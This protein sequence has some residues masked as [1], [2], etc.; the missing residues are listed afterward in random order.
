MSPF[1]ACVLWLAETEIPVPPLFSQMAA[2]SV[3]SLPP[4]ASRDPPCLSF[5]LFCPVRCARMLLL[6]AGQS[7]GE[8]VLALFCLSNEILMGAL[9]FFSSVRVIQHFS[10][11]SLLRTFLAR[12]LAQN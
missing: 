5:G 3:D 11:N 7:R 1:S 9:L 6:R 10:G 8:I 2:V 4:A 12:A